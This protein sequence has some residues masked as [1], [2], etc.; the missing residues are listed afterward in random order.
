MTHQTK[1]VV[2]FSE[3]V[4]PLQSIG[5][6]PVP[7]WCV[8]MRADS[9]S[10]PATLQVVG[11]QD[12]SV[13]T[14]HI[15]GPTPFRVDA[16]ARLIAQGLAYITVATSREALSEG[17]APPP[18]LSFPV[19]LDRWRVIGTPYFDDETLSPVPPDKRG[20]VNF[21][22]LGLTYSDADARGAS[23]SLVD[24]DI[25]RFRA[26]RLD[27]Y[28]KLNT[29]E[30]ADSMRVILAP[31]SESRETASDWGDATA[32]CAFSASGRLSLVLDLSTASILTTGNS[33]ATAP[34]FAA[35]F[36]GL[37]ASTGGSIF[38]IAWSAYG[39]MREQT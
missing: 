1:D 36:I 14:R 3:L 2:L 7:T 38:T 17:V 12:T 30:P 26:L 18:T 23:Y 16:G 15:F 32:L 31:W 25:Y 13:R 28:W 19:V 22:G 5:P 33:Y 29:G 35:P 4:S 20:A 10:Y 11:T 34:L 9:G 6:F 37:E 27:I 24:P 8:L 21:K 39:L